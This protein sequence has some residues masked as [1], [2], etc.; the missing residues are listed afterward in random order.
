MHSNKTKTWNHYKEIFQICAYNITYSGPFI[1]GE[2]TSV[3][4]RTMEVRCNRNFV[5]KKTLPCSL[6]F[7]SLKEQV[8]IYRQ[9]TRVLEF[10]TSPWLTRKSGRNDG[11]V[12]TTALQRALC[13]RESFAKNRWYLLS[14]AVSMINNFRG[15]G[16]VGQNCLLRMTRWVTPGLKRKIVAPI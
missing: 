7:F 4:N 16:G 14:A 10:D 13:A 2:K 12:T 11:H 3:T 9:N 15:G 8:A 6:C 5:E 1:L